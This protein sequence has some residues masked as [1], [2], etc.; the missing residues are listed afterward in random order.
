M[1]KTL[2]LFSSRTGRTAALADAIAEGASSVRFAEVDVRLLPALALPETTGDPQRTSAQEALLRRYRPLEAVERLGDYD[3][4]IL[5]APT[6]N[7]VVA[8][9]LEHLLRQ[10][11]TLFGGGKLVDRAGS[12]FT[13]VP[14]GGGGAE[15]ALWSIMKPLAAMGM[16]LVPPGPAGGNAADSPYGATATG[17]RDPGPAELSVARHQGKRVA[18]VAAMVAHVR[19]H[20][21][22]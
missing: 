11:G 10:A 15:A 2:V 6:R 1:P 7:G 20:H 8:A 4:L 21:H 3:G 9:E 5:G 14:E 16:I 12:A 18:T 19:S 22:H 13:T 17:D